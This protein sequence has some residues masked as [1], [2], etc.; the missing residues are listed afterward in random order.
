MAQITLNLKSNSQSFTINDYDI[1]YISDLM[2]DGVLSGSILTIIDTAS[3]VTTTIDVEEEPA[4]VAALST[5]LIDI[6]LQGGSHGYVNTSRIKQLIEV[7]DYANIRYDDNGN[8]F[9]II[10]TTMTTAEI[11]ALM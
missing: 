10:K 5:I 9:S 4:D 7:G 6:D 3:A 1:I 11:L 2:V 8:V